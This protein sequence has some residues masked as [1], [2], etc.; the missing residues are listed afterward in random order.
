MTPLLARA[1]LPVM[2]L[3]APLQCGA[4]LL[5]CEVQKNG[6]YQC[7]EISEPGTTPATTTQ[8]ES[9]GSTYN[10]FREQAKSRCTYEEPRKRA[11]GKNTGAASRTEDIKSA[12]KDYE[13]C[14]NEHARALWQQ[15]KADGN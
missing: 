8:E 3:S 12:R 1:I 14:I 11:G 4:I 6:I 2:L 9:Y 7:I 13:Q 5:D 15:H 10:E